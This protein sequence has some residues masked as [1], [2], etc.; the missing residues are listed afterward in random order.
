MSKKEKIQDETVQVKTVVKKRGG[1]GSFFMGFL[2]TFVFLIVCIGGVGLYCYYNVTLTQIENIIGLKL[3]IEGDIRDKAIKDLIALGLEYKDSY[4]EAT[5]DTVQKDFGVK[6]PETIPGTEISLTPIYNAEINFL[7]K[8]QKV[9]SYRIQ[10][11]VNNLNEFVDAVLPVFYA[12]TT[13]NQILK[14]FNVTLL[15]DLG[16]PALVDDYYNV[17]TASAP[18]MKSLGNLTIQQALDI[19]PK[20]FS[21]N[22]LTVQEIVNA[23]GL[24][25]M[26]YP[27]SG[28]KDVYAG[29]RNLIVTQITTDQILENA[30]GALLNNLL[31]LSDFAFTQTDEFNSTKLS[32]MMDYIKTVPLNQIM[33]I[34]ETAPTET[35]SATDH[36]LYAI[37]N[38]TFNDLQSNDPIATLTAKIDINYPTLTL[39]KLIDF[40][41]MSNLDFLIDVKLTSLINDTTATINNVLA[42]VFIG[43][44][45]TLGSVVKGN[46]NFFTDVTIFRNVNAGIN[47]SQLREVIA[48]LKISEILTSSQLSTSTLSDAQKQMT[49]LE[50]LQS[51]SGITLGTLLN[52]GQ[53]SDLVASLGGYV[54][55]LKDVTDSTFT[56][57]LNNTKIIDLIGA[58]NSPTALARLGDMD[59]KTISESDDLILILADN[60]GTLGNLLNVSSSDGFLG[61]I[62]NVEFA[63]LLGS[64]PSGAIMN[65]LKNSN[66]TLANLLGKTFEN[67]LINS[68]MT[69]KVGELFGD[70]PEQAFKNALAGSDNTLGSVFGFDG[71]QTAMMGYLANVKFADILG[72]TAGISPADAILNAIIGNATDGYTTLASFLGNTET[73][74]IMSMLST[75]TMRDLLGKN[76]EVTA[77]QAIMNALGASGKNLGELLNITATDG[78]AGIVAGLSLSDLFGD[79]ANATLAL[80]NIVNSIKLIDVFTNISTLPDTNV[81]KILYDNNNN[82]LVKDISTAVNNITLAQVLGVTDSSPA[83]GIYTLIENLT[84]DYTDTN[85]ILHRQVTIG[86]LNDV[87]V[88]QNLT[89]LDLYNAGMLSDSDINGLS[90]SEKSMTI[91]QFLEA[92]KTLKNT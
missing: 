27:T 44:F 86:T 24:S 1:C 39:G 49:M 34:S 89:I 45:V 25:I 16:Y 10:D 30:D 31:D 78:I 37:R 85:S 43:D 82:L 84:H 61:I 38:A 59:L 81:L 28:Q 18:V 7:S 68:I 77:G 14:S 9:T 60:F 20:H 64:D 29:L 57:T 8:T 74:G 76:S 15:N 21:E 53:G 32:N 54:Y 67:N 26:P 48:S 52:M 70:N 19:L 50:L 17:G 6:L 91:S 65:E 87:V 56:A 40:S 36:L 92:Y 12:N 46:P 11:I 3:P 80:N 55:A 79:S 41:D 33:N 4:T 58:E 47:L 71:S 2:F 90:E 13:V 88:K 51:N 5:L 35:S 83:T 23:V 75:V 73:D 69:I 72:M 63:D 42:N 66:Q 22:N 62:G